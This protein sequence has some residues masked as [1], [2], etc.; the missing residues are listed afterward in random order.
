MNKP[1]FSISSLDPNF[2]GQSILEHLFPTNNFASLGFQP[3]TGLLGTRT[4]RC[5][6]CVKLQEFILNNLQLIKREFMIKIEDTCQGE[7]AGNLPLHHTKLTMLLK[8]MDYSKK[9]FTL[10]FCFIFLLFFVHNYKRK[11]IKA[12]NLDFFYFFFL[13]QSSLPSKFY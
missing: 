7:T 3:T 4:H 13:D 5:W 8:L 9:R 11:K 1:D 6:H 12:L 10:K 2:W